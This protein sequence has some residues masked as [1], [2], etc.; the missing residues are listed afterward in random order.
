M[1]PAT[2]SCPTET[3]VRLPKMTKA[4]LGGMIG[5]IVAAQAL[6]AAAKPRE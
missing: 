5:P 6:I 3:E 1:M 4:T 2:K